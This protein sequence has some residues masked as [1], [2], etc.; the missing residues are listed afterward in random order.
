MLLNVFTL[1]L[2]TAVI[3]ILEETSLIFYIFL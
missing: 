1:F 2:I 3:N